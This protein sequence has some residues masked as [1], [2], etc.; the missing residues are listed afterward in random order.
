MSAVG[1]PQFSFKERGG[2]LS[3]RAFSMAGKRPFP[4]LPVPCSFCLRGA[5]DPC[6]SDI[7]P[8]LRMTLLFHGLI[9]MPALLFLVRVRSSHSQAGRPWRS[10]AFLQAPR[11]GCSL[12][13]GG[14]G[15]RRS[16]SDRIISFRSCVPRGLGIICWKESAVPFL[17]SFFAP[18]FSFLL[19]A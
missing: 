15:S 12:S 17:S 18:H 6:Y 10:P 16:T 2:P 7:S 4:G 14:C 1:E 8:K 11:A 3:S 13:L 9:S 5:R 19:W